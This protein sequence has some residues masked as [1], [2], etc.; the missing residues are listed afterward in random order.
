MLEQGIIIIHHSN[1][2][3][4]V[5]NHSLEIND[6]S[7]W[8]GGSHEF[9][10]QIFVGWHCWLKVMD[11]GQTVSGFHWCYCDYVIVMDWRGSD[12]GEENNRVMVFYL[13][14]HKSMRILVTAVFCHILYIY[15]IIN[16]IYMGKPSGVF[17]GIN[18]TYLYTYRDI[19]GNLFLLSCFFFANIC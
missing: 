9:S 15:I 5:I 11:K 3:I 17:F 18:L 7:I 12:R 13:F 10:V 4:E 6:Q 19:N 2:W 8:I 16:D 14:F 1:R